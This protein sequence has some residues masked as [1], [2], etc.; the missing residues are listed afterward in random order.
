[1]Y[2]IKG[3]DV[4]VRVQICFADLKSV[5]ILMFSSHEC[6]VCESNIVVT[7]QLLCECWYWGL[8]YKNL[9]CSF[10]Q[11]THSIFLGVYNGPGSVVRVSGLRNQDDEKI[12]C[13]SGHRK[14]NF[15][16]QVLE[17]VEVFTSSDS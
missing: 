1:M 11:T 12:N 5:L 15:F 10:L 2:C 16:I 9:S 8:K 4:N 7:A 6:C 14:E 13:S 3:L 17:C